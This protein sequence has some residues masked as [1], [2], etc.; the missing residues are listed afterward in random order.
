MGG[1]GI[2]AVGL[3]WLVSGLVGALEGGGSKQRGK[4]R[5]GNVE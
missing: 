4:E 2:Q 5:H 3:E 1:D